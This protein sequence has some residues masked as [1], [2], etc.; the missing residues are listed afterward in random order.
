MRGVRVTHIHIS[1][2]HVLYVSEQVKQVYVVLCPFY[3]YCLHPAP[4]GWLR[5][6]FYLLPYSIAVRTLLLSPHQVKVTGEVKPN[7]HYC[8]GTWIAIE[9]I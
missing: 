1:V 7:R 4:K 2:D 6:R 8:W 5:K 9:N 3:T